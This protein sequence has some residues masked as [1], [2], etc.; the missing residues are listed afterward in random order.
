MALVSVIINTKNEERNI[1]NCLESIGGQ[2]FPISEIEV[3][4]VDNNSTDKTLEMVQECITR[5]APLNI[6]LFNWGPERSAQKN[7]GVE[8]SRGEYFIHLDADMTLS[9]DV[10]F[11]CVETMDSDPDLVGLYIPEIVLGE[12]YFCQV[13]RFERN[14]YD[15]TVIDGLRFIRK[16]KFLKAG[17]FDEN[18][19]ACED[20]DLDKRLKK[21][22]RVAV[23]KSA[24]YH[25]E[26]DFNLK[27]YLAKKEYYSHNFE[28]Y[29]SKWGK[30]D[31][32]IR[33]QFGFYYRFIG[34]FVENKKWK[35]IIAHP[36]LVIG[37]IFLRILV[38]ITFTKNKKA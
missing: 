13:R 14:F 33:K 28:T 15:G 10:I 38:G 11:E 6:K 17:K 31:P 18:L 35:K 26:E 20:W 29:I 8:K 24:L 2:S 7:F 21:L 36:I 32:D 3:L 22:S 37:I 19:Y 23:I 34:I 4:V 25:H 27:K 5:Y 16:D 12:S 1:Q 30:N 9:R